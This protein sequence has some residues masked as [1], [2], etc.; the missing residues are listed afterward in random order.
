M[1]VDTQEY[2]FSG[3]RCN[4]SLCLGAGFTAE[5][6][7]LEGKALRTAQNGQK[8]VTATGK[9]KSRGRASLL[10]TPACAAVALSQ[11]QVAVLGWTGALLCIPVHD[12]LQAEPPGFL[13]W[14]SPTEQRLDN[15]GEGAAAKLRMV[16]LDSHAAVPQSMR[17]IPASTLGGACADSPLQVRTSS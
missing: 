17:E 14:K 7:A 13:M 6:D 10:R 2:T 4:N 1:P 9:R 3:E 11:E 5:Q 16:V 12:L 8:P 15:A